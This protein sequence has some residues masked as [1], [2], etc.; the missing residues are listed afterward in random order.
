MD[1][2]LFLNQLKIDFNQIELYQKAFQHVSFTNRNKKLQNYETLEFFGDSI[3]GF[4]VAEY[5]FAKFH[6]NNDP[7]EKII[8]VG[9]LSEYKQRLVSD[10]V[11][12][13][14][15]LKLGMNEFACVAPNTKKQLNETTILAD[16]F[17]AF[18]AALYS[19]LG[20]SAVRT[21]L[22]ENLIIPF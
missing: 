5:L 9:T 15:A 1:L 17:E 7:N 3:V 18:T 16:I 6:Q 21:F 22:R 4:V 11:L 10:A 14:A 12:T 13:K 19:D 20:L 8:L 2:S